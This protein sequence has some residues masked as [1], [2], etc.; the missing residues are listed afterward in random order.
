MKANL[1]IFGC[2]LFVLTACDFVVKEPAIVEGTT[3]VKTDPLPSWNDGAAKSSIM[4]YVNSVTAQG[5]PSFIPVEDR[6]AT[7]DNDGNLWAEQPAYF[8]LFFALDQIKAMAKDHP[9]WQDQEPFKSVLNDDMDGIMATGMHGLMEIIMNSH[10]GSSSDDYRSAVSQ[11]LA[12]SKHP[13]FNVGYNQLIYQPMLELL[14][15]LR[16]N[17]FKV[18]IVS[19][20]GVD[21]MRVWATEAYGI[22]S[23]Q[24][25][26]SSVKAEYS[27]QNGEAKIIKL[28]ELNFIDDK[29]G[30]PVGIHQYIGKKPVFASGNS[31]GDLQMLQYCDS[32]DYPSFHV[33]DCPAFSLGLIESFVQFTNM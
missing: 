10:T 22:P 26:G 21:F 30:K 6:I 18:F 13:R 11:W 1:L 9:E 2:V 5:S 25:I 24:I 31:D 12:T 4:N 3:S 16:A 32:N 20:G 14:D 7:F 17:D 29:E 33:N 28:P 27:Y 23:D 8:Q 15:Y 19:G